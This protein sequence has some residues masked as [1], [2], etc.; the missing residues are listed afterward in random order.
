MLR[1]MFVEDTKK[2]VSNHKEVLELGVF[3]S[4]CALIL[5]VVQ[6]TKSYTWTVVTA[7]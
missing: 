6:T 1:V 3:W 2:M 7:I 5:L 4:N